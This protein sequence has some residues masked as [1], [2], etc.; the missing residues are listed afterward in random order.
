MKSPLVRRSTYR[1]A[2]RM[3][4]RLEDDLARAQ[5]ELREER[6]KRDLPAV[7][8]LG[9]QFDRIFDEYAVPKE[10][11]VFYLD[12]RALTAVLRAGGRALT[13]GLADWAHGGVAANAE[14]ATLKLYGIE[15]LPR[16]EL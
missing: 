2:L 4:A 15:F 7:T 16:K 12:P 9:Q 10:E 5:H 3:I 14:F 6:G 11:R 8:E 1:R 13:V